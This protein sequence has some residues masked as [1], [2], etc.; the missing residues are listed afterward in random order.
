MRALKIIFILNSFNIIK[1]KMPL[2]LLMDIGSLFYAL[3]KKEC[4]PS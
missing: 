2:S 1:I 3:V 4:V